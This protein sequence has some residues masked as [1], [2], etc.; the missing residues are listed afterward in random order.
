MAIT[1]PDLNLA[2]AERRLVRAAL[3]RAGSLVEALQ[4]SA[5]SPSAS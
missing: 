2:E 1:L 3:T 5:P 4:A